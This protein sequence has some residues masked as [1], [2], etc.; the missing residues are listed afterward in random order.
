MM[1]LLIYKK[2]LWKA[3]EDLNYNLLN[4][5]YSYKTIKKLNAAYPVMPCL[6]KDAL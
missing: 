1:V 6:Q 5:C 2:S 3:T 4:S